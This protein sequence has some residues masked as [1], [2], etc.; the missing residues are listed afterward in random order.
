MPIHNLP[1]P[2]YARMSSAINWSSLKQMDTS[3]LH[4]VHYRAKPMDDNANLRVGRAAH[5]AILEP[6]MFATEYVLWPKRRAGKD[7]T[8]F[9]ELHELNGNAILNQTEYDLALALRDAFHLHPVANNYLRD[10]THREVSITWTDAATGLECKA[11]PDLV[12]AD[13]L[14]DIKTAANHTL[15]GFGR[16]AG[17][18]AYHTQLA[19]YLDS[20]REIDDRPRRVVLVAIEKKPPHDVACYVVTD[21]LISIGRRHYRALLDRLVECQRT[22]SWPGVAPAETDLQIPDWA[23]ATGVDDLDWDGIEVVA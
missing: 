5:C 3:P 16:A 6:E 12:T 22:N 2:E 13:T 20:L 10:S 21:D 4:Y 8:E 9:K 19:W 14:V 1:F 17:S 23:L 7:W 18:Y 15:D 11:R